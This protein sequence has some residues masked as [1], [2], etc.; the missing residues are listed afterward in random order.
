MSTLNRRVSFHGPRRSNL[1]WIML[2]RKFYTSLEFY[3]YLSQ[4]TIPRHS[5]YLTRFETA[6]D[7]MPGTPN[8]QTSQHQILHMF[9]ITVST[10]RQYATTSSN[11]RFSNQLRIRQKDGL[12]SLQ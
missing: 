11:Q 8:Q 10:L 3:R 9:L 5:F 2:F 4:Y 1:T 6:W 12:E 7:R